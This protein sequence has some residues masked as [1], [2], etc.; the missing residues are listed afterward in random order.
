MTPSRRSTGGS[1]GKRD[2]TGKMRAAVDRPV[3]SRTRRDAVSAAFG[4][5]IRKLR[6]NAGMSQAELAGDKLTRFAISKIESGASMPTL[7]TL[8]YLASR[9]GVTMR[10]LLPPGF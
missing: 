9:L 3:R 8:D 4:A 2:S 1:L 5:R 7:E 10:D 6:Q